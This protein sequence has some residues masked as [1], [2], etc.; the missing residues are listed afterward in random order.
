MPICAHCEREVEKTYPCPLCK[1][2]YC[3]QHIKPD[4][5]NCPMRGGR[6]RRTKPARVREPSSPIAPERLDDV[7]Q[8]I[9]ELK[10]TRRS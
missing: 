7:M 6:K 2:R 4:A 5:H 1:E 8:Y 9:R 3:P 10:K